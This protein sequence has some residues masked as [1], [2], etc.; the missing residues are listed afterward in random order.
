MSL[1]EIFN[2]REAFKQKIV[3]QIQSDLEKFGIE[4]KAA[5]LKVKY[6]NKK[7]KGIIR[8]QTIRLFF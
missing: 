6:F 1:E 3:T 2:D 5:N 7:K 4:I 8:Y